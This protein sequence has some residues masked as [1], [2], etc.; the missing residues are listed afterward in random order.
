MANDRAELI[1][2]LRANVNELLV[3]LGRIP[4]SDSENGKREVTARLPRRLRQV[5][6]LILLGWSEKEMSYALKLSQHTIHVYTKSLYKLYHVCSRAE[7]MSLWIAWE[8]LPLLQATLP[9]EPRPV[10]VRVRSRRPLPGF[11]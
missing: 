11:A 1:A 2:R 6:Y 5:L 7:L 4:F 10:H 8:Q 9:P 3:A